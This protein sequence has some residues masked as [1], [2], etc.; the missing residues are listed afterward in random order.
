M[1]QP[2]DAQGKQ[3]VSL[4]AEDTAHATG[5]LGRAIFA[6]RND[7]PSSLADT[8]GDYLP[9]TTDSS[10][11][12]HV[13]VG[14]TVTVGSHAVT[15][16][17]TFAVQAEGDVAHDAVDSGNPLKVGGKARTTNP[18]AVADADR[19]DAT[20]DDVGRQIVKLD[21]PRD[22]QVTQHT[23]ITTSTSE[24]TVLTA[25]AAGVFHDVTSIILTNTSA[26]ATTATIKDATAGTTRL[27]IEIP[28]NDT[29]GVSFSH[30]LI[31]AVAANNW[32][33]TSDQSITSLEVTVN[34][35]KNV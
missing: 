3:R 20:F 7:T 24:T 15:N 12:L 14:N 2:T 1:G 31:Q 26:T 13:N 21:A 16:A 23:T 6:V 18:T 27:V 25:G 17:G 33:V 35:V 4:R 10:G 28:A 19:V 5:D 32:T 9:L 22:L 30:P 34:A 8:D 29:R 11:R